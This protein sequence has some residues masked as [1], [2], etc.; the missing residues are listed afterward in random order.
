MSF[1]K[2]K[3]KATPTNQFAGELNTSLSPGVAT[4][5]ASTNFLGDLLGIGKGTA[6]EG[7]EGYKE[8]A[9]YAPALRDM[10]QGI[11]GGAAAAGLLNSGSTQKALLKGG[12]DLDKSTFGNFMQYLAGLSGIGLQGAS[13]ISGAGNVALNQQP[14]TGANIMQAIG[15]IASIFSDRAC[16]RDIHLLRR[17]DDGLGLHSFRYIWDDEVRLGVM[18]D[19]VA[20]LQP[21]A[22]GPVVGG[23]ATVNYGAL[24]WA[25]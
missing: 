9:G 11:T 23:Y 24:K 16:K 13:T 10:Q 21:W 19:E 5:A 6:K 4:G 22:L 1:L 7:F 2:P 3:I 8:M 12:A 20:D 14:S 17:M 25:F 18:A 15:G